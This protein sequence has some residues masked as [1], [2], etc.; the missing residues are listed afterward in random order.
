MLMSGSSEAQC[1]ALHALKAS[2]EVR[3]SA[4]WRRTISAG[5]KRGALCRVQSRVRPSG[6][7]HNYLGISSAGALEFDV[8]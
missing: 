8:M 2:G 7:G 4:R 3:G 1:F 5:R 6:V